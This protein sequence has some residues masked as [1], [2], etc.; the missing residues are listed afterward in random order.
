MVINPSWL[1]WEVA[2]NPRVLTS[3]IRTQTKCAK[4]EMKCSQKIVLLLNFLLNSHKLA[5]SLIHRNWISSVH[6]SGFIKQ[7]KNSIKCRTG[8][9]VNEWQLINMKWAALFLRLKLTRSFYRPRSSRLPTRH[10]LIIPRLSKWVF[11]MG[12]ICEYS[13]SPSR[14]PFH[15]VNL[16]MQLKPDSRGHARTLWLIDFRGCKT[17]SFT[18][19]RFWIIA[20]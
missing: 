17:A 7:L 15:A 1:L 9:S 13:C 4:E 20:G 2:N 3:A 10:V 8:T 14:H 5:P 6:S 11:E 18:S 19:N 12:W 16:V